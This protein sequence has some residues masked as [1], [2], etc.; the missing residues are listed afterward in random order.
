GILSDQQLKQTQRILAQLKQ[1]AKATP[2][3]QLTDTIEQDVTAQTRLGAD[4]SRLAAQFLGKKAPRF[5]LTGLDGKPLSAKQRTGKIIVLHFWGY[6]S[7]PLVE[8][9]GQIGYLDFLHNRRHKLGV[10]I[11]GV[12]V[13]ESLTPN[14]AESPKTLR[15]VRKLREFM[16]L[17]YPLTIDDGQL[18]RKF[19]DPRTLDAKLPLWVVIAPNGTIAGYQVG[20]FSIRADEGLKQLDDLLI[21]LIRQQKAATR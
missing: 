2:F 1:Q 6:Q 7:E 14:S 3:A 17:S 20:L 18:L 5:T 16:N 11:F 19:G 9:Y 12:A 10:Q 15:S 13:H 4:I 21:K 8:P